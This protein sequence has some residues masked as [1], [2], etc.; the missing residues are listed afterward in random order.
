MSIAA[1]RNGWSGS[2]LAL[3]AGA[4][5]AGAFAPYGCWPLAVLCP[6]LLMWLWQDVRPRRAAALGFYFGAGTFAAGTW[7]LYI[8]IHT[9]GAAPVWLALLLMLALVTIMG[10]YHALI[11]YLANRLL[12]LGGLW[13]W[14]LGLPSLW[15]L[16]EWLLS[17]IHI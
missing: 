1:L 6:A 17:L 4:L 7:W 15:L 12:P 5:L 13:R 11:G 9:I 2:A 14:W 16:V 3:V 10:A 8:A